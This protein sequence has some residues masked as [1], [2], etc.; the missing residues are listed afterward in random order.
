MKPALL[1][2][3]LITPLVYGQGGASPL[4]FEQGS[5]SHSWLIRRVAFEKI[6]PV[7]LKPCQ[8]PA[9][10]IAAVIDLLA[11]ETSNPNWEELAEGPDF[12]SYY[13][14]LLMTVRAIA[15]DTGNPRAF[16]AL[17]NSQYNPDSEF[18]RWLSAQPQALSAIEENLKSTYPIQRAF[19]IQMLAQAAV[20]SDKQEL[21]QKSRTIAESKA[22]DEKEN[23]FILTSAMKALTTLG[24]PASVATLTQIADT[25][26]N[27]DI[28]KYARA[29]L[30]HLNT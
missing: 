6:C 5:Q 3:S 10:N 8:P 13:S 11:R 9:E 24:G 21:R 26:P 29:C 4:S 18:G 27:P 28:Q 1:L 2:L 20:H 23:G 12:E 17:V 14:T 30:K 22:V 25:D 19:A 15:T 16:R 7:K